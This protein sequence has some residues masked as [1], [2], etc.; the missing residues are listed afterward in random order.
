MTFPA[1]KVKV[2]VGRKSKVPNILN[3]CLMTVIGDTQD[4][5]AKQPDHVMLHFITTLLSD[6]NSSVN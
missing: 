3:P 1:G 5:I 6:G 2:E 4:A